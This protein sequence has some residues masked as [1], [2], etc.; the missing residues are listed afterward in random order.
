MLAPLGAL[1]LL[2][3]SNIGGTTSGALAVA[4]VVAVLLVVV[5]AAVWRWVVHHPEDGVEPE[6]HGVPMVGSHRRDWDALDRKPV[7]SRR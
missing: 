7:G 6:P 1:P 4:G 5:A 3:L 2:R